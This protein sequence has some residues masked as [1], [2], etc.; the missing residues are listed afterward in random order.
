MTSPRQP[1][2][3]VLASRTFTTPRHTTHYLECG[4]ADGPLMVFLHGWPGI[5]LMWRAQLDAFAAD[6]WH[7]VA[8][9]LRG[10][11]GSSAPADHRRLHARA[12]RR[13]HG[14]APR[15]PRRRARDLGRSRL[16]QRR[17][18]RPRRTRPR[19]R[20]GGGVD[21][22]GVLPRRQHPGHAGARWSTARSTRPTSTPTASGT[23]TATTRRTSRPLSPTSTP[24]RPPRWRRSTG[25]AIPRRSER[26][27]RRRRSRAAAA[28]SAPPTAP[29][30]RTPDPTCGRRRT[31]TS[32]CD[33]FRPTGFRPSCAWYTND[34][35]NIAY[36]RTAPDRGRLAQPVLFVNG[37]LDQICT[38]DGNRQGD[39]MRAACTD[40]TVTTLPAGHWLP[41]ERKAEL[42]EA[43]RAWLEHAGL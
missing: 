15:P 20:R 2:S 35:A 9:D 41:L 14:R 17:R 8:P 34:A 13:R 36:A 21:L 19:A 1:T 40:L 11:G 16:G 30:R 23:T 12:G 38:I 26:S 33:A 3:S 29:R 6:G 7:C 28:A 5:G 42:V 10:Y 32:S 4:P 22:V 43:I 31:S 24:T 39:P 37:D 25:R 18:R 27:R